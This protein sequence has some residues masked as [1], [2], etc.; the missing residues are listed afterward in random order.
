MIVSATSIKENSSGSILNDLYAPLPHYRYRV[1]AQEAL[2]FCSD[3]KTLGNGL[4]SVLEKR[5]AEEIAL[6]RAGHELKMLQVI[7]D[8]KKLQLDEA[9]ENLSSLKTMRK[10]TEA[11]HDYY[12]KIEKINSK[13]QLN[14]NK[15]GN[16]RVRQNLSEKNEKR[17]ARSHHIPNATTGSVLSYTFG[18]SNLG[19]IANATAASNRNK[20]VQF[21]YEASK[22]SIPAGHDRR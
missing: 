21:A 12:V 5:D 13:E 1:M 11:R 20:S 18:G 22:A 19:A 6:L 4:L 14:L 7:S 2:E 10:I 9:R 8:V 16:S 15:L 3:V 17:A